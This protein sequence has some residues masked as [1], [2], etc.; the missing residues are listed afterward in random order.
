M[1]GGTLRIPGGG[2]VMLD[3]L[4]PLPRPL[5]LIIDLCGGGIDDN[6]A[7]G[8]PATGDLTASRLC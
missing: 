3:V 5:P 6:L 4:P 1:G 7:G 8:F 2:P